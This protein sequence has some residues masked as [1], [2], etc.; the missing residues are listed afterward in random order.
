V[1]HWHAF[2]GN[3][4]TDGLTGDANDEIHSPSLGVN[5]E[6]PTPEAGDNYVNVSL[7]LPRGNSLSTSW[8]SLKD[9]KEAYPVA[10][11]E[12]AV[13]HGIDDD[14]AFNWWVHAVL[15]KRGHIIALVKKRSTRFLK[16]THK[17]GIELPRSVAEAYALDKKNGN[18]LRADSIAKEMKNVQVAFKILAKGEKVPIGFQHMG[19]HMI[20]DIKMEDLRRKSRLIAGVLMTDAPATTMF[21]SV[22]SRKTV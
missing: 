1:K 11:T 9:L 10:V 14:P 16:K 22:V 8:Q 20:F 7:M 12:Y 3:G 19:C 4:L 5:V 2:T 17:F 13:A 21:A 6:L 18:T 15:R